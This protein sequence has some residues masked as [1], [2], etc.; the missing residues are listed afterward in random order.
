MKDK[1]LKK[2][3]HA[4]SLWKSGGKRFDKSFSFTSDSI[5]KD[6]ITGKVK[7]TPQF[8]E[9][10]FHHF[11]ALSKNITQAVKFHIPVPKDDLTTNEIKKLLGDVEPFLPFKNTFLQL[12]MDDDSCI[13]ALLCERGGVFHGNLAYV[14]EDEKMIYIDPRT[15]VYNLGR[16][17]EETDALRFN[18]WHKTEEEILN[19]DL[20][21]LLPEEEKSFSLFKLNKYSEKPKGKI[22]K[23]FDDDYMRNGKYN[24][25]KTIMTLAKSHER[26]ML[27]LAYPQITKRQEVKGL[28]NLTSDEASKVAKILSKKKL[29]AAEEIFYPKYQHIQV[30][31]DI[32]DTPV[33]SEESIG[34]GESR[35]FHAVRKHIRKYKNGK[36]SFVKAH[37]RGDKRKGI[38]SK[39]YLITAEK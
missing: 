26:L 28:K 37:F 23:N 30:K 4:A 18:F 15:I 6:S 32:Y 8:L 9:D 11:Q 1:Y 7:D 22:R 16:Y 25:Y 19:S 13:F 21:F 38:I 17:E 31:L 34:R 2:Y 33:E 35:C 36:L 29:S 3:I 39:E 14:H 10:G 5:I 12:D 24:T 27:Y 20:N